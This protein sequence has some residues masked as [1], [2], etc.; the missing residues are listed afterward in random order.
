MSMR[1]LHLVNTGKRRGAET[2]ASDLVAALNQEG[3]TQAVAVLHGSTPGAVAFDAPVT[4][5]GPDGSG[6]R[7]VRMAPRLLSEV[8]SHLQNWGPDLVHAHGGDTL[9]YST[10]AAP[11]LRIP[12]V[13]RSIGLAPDWILRGPR[14]VAYSFLLRRANRVVAVADVIRR[15]LLDVFGLSE[16]RVVTIPNAADPRRLEPSRD[17]EDVRRELGIPPAHRVLLSLGALSWEKDPMSHLEVASRIMGRLP[18]VTHLVVGDGPMRQQVEQAVSARGLDG[19]VLVLGS[20]GDVAD[21]LCASD[22]VLFASRPDGMEGMPAAIIEA[23]ML[24]LPVV[25]YAVAGAGDVILDGQS[26][27]LVAPGDLDGL[28]ECTLELLDNE[29]KRRRLGEAAAERCRSRYDIRTV[30]GQYLTVSEQLIG[31][32]AGSRA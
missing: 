19:R 9:K 28:V 10:L 23:G 5:L 26:G 29:A 30:A 3:V 8:R 13:Y 15:Q 4:V 2:F 17:R 31:E 11:R 6:G 32:K 1:V 24:G 16:E 22:I 7:S 25:G 21:L 14:R 20:R 27:R 18:D 12:V